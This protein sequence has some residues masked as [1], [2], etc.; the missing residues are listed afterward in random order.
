MHSRLLACCAVAL[1]AAPAAA[2]DE[3]TFDVAQF[4]K[5][6]FELNGYAELRLER[7]ALDRDAALYQLNF[8]DR[9]SRTHLNRATGALE[10]PGLYRRGPTTLQATVHGEA[11]DDELQSDSATRLYE[12]YLTL[13]ASMRARLEA[14]K[15]ALRWGK[16]YAFNPVGFVE[17]VKDPNDPEQSREGFVLAAGNFIRSFDGPLK[18][19]AF[20]PLVV[21][22]SGHVNEDFGTG[23]HANPAAKLT[24]LYYDTD[25]DFLVLGEGARSMRYGFVFARNLATNFEIHGEWARITD[26]VK[27][28]LD[29]GGNQ[30]RQTRDVTRY[31]LGL[32]HLSRHDTTTILEYYYNGGGYT[33]SQM[34]DYFTFVHTAYDQFLATGDSALLQR[35]TGVRSAWARPCSP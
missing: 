7:F 31:L 1:L 26:S 13:Q 3:Y 25:F 19:L 20:T 12:G 34:R 11:A 33:E 8:F 22:T 29:A 10:L 27:P 9:E 24:L 30:T 18:T 21:P 32:R 23:T 5:Q 14:G 15:R 2:Q 35:A 16:G 6:P 28:V 17:R 4:E